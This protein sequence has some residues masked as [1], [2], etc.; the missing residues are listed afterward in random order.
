MRPRDRGAAKPE[1]LE[2]FTNSPFMT[3][4][5]MLERPA[6]FPS[7]GRR[8]TPLHDG[9]QLWTEHALR[10]YHKAFPPGGELRLAQKAWAYRHLRP[11]TDVEGAT[12]YRITAWGRCF[13]SADGRLRELRLPVTRLRERSDTERAVAALVAAE[14]EGDPRVEEV[15]VVQFALS[16]GRPAPVFEGSRAQA[17]AE[18]REYGAS[19][20]RA[21]PDNQEYRPGSACVSC[22]VASVCPALPK[23]EGLLGVADRG[24]P[25]RS[26]SSTTGRGHAKCPARGHLRS[27]RLPL[28]DE[29]ERNAAAERGRAVHD[30]LAERHGRLP[31]VPC[32]SRIPADWVPKKYQLPDEEIRLGAELL[33]HHAEVCPLRVAGAQSEIRIEPRL[34]FDDTAADLLVLTAPDLFEGP[35][36]FRTGTQ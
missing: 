19:A 30:F 10:M 17:L 20:V 29:V 7:E 31:A 13:E 27:L 28:N 24:R 36:S 16:D 9:L 1:A 14:G 18:Y 5:D 3:A 12:L 2:T 35:R 6:D 11:A 33:R 8:R 15:R 21:L 4:A 23:A 25:R 32:T 26:W 22:A 34:V